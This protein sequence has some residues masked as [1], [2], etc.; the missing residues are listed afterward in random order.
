MYVF[1]VFVVCWGGGYSERK[2]EEE[3]GGFIPTLQQGFLKT[4][5]LED[6]RTVLMCRVQYMVYMYV[7]VCSFKVCVGVWV[8][9]GCVRVCMEEGAY[10]ERERWGRRGRR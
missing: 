8:G 5:E 4:L 3:G 1:V 9:F 2:Q 10:R 7:H 6:A